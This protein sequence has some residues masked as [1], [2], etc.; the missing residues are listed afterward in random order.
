MDT[1]RKLVTLRKL[2]LLNTCLT[3][4]K[5]GKPVSIRNKDYYLKCREYFSIEKFETIF[6][7]TPGGEELRELVEKTLDLFHEEVKDREPWTEQ[8][9]AQRHLTN[10]EELLTTISL[11]N[12]LYYLG[13]RG[14]ANRNVKK[15]KKGSLS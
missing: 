9:D 15:E 5:K 8:K 10:R 4:L 11:Q 7:R 1:F 14:L 12:G 13:V 2:F 6:G 3:L